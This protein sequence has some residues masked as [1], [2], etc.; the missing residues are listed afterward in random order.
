M[1]LLLAV[2]HVEMQRYIAQNYKVSVAGVAENIEELY[3]LITYVKADTL[4]ISRSLSGDSDKRQV[5]EQITNQRKDLRIIYL[6]GESDRDTDEFLKYLRSKS[7]VDCYV[8]TNVTSL[9]LD[10]LLLGR[11][12]YKGEGVLRQLIKRPKKTMWVKELDSAVITVYS[13]SSNG[14]SHLAWN[15]A[16][17]LSERGYKTTLI[18]LDRGYSANIYFGIPDIYYDLLEYLVS[19][20]RHRDIID[21]CY[22]K[23]SLNVVTGR[24]GSETSIKEVDFLKLFYFIRSKSNVV[25]I[26]TCT[27]L[28]EITLQAIN[29]SNIDFLIFD[30]DLMHFHMNK[31]M[32][33]QLDSNFIAEKTYAIINNCTSVSESYKYIYKQ[34]NKL[35]E[36]FKGI[37]PLSSCGSLSCDLMHTGRTPYSVLNNLNNG[38]KNDMNNI[39]KTINAREEGKRAERI[40]K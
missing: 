14:K 24:L 16:E 34:I 30:T 29:N 15:L 35:N 13:N 27:G 25:I 28:N 26:D 22:K 37:L 11:D 1:R 10:R 40:Y 17:E 3:E 19:E 39:L 38:F 12:A 33:Q 4:I 7:I 31:Q 2:N 9:E 32:I 8:G 6:Y 5:I 20:E 21:S 23:G 36:K 18:N